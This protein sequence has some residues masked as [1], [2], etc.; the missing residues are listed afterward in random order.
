MQISDI[1][2][3]ELDAV[4]ALNEASVPHVSSIDIR[5]VRWFAE[6][7]FYFRSA[8]VDGRFAGFLIPLL[9]AVRLRYN[10]ALHLS[11]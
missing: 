8:Q 1:T 7:A 10:S 2:E 4:L 5:Q 6:H 3:I 11:R 9:P